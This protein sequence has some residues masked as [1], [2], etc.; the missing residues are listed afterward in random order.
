MKHRIVLA[1]AFA[2][3]LG[4]SSVHADWTGINATGATITFKNPN[5]CASV[6]CVPIAQPVDSTGASFGVTANPMFVAPGSGQTF[7]ISASSLPLPTGAATSAPLQSTINTTLG[8]PFQAGGSIGNTSFAATQATAA[9]LNATVVGAGTVG[10]PSAQVVSVQ[11]AASMTPILT[12][13]G[14]AANWSVGATGSAVPANAN[15]P[16]A[17]GSGNLTGEIVCDNS[18]VYDASTSGSTQLVGLVSGKTIYVC[19][20]AI[21]TGGTATNVKL[22]YGT[23]TACATGATSLTPAYQIIANGGI[24]DHASNHWGGMKTAA[25][26]ELCI[27]ASA[28]NAVQATVYYTQF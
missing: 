18:V 12:N 10:T 17:N 13:P 14:T 2:C 20:Y 15:Y 6:V 28:A 23:G 26:N 27:N 25:S 7:P 19:G 24:V 4:I 21:T 1:S 11:G 9:N 8:S 5:N 3:L 22:T 16:G